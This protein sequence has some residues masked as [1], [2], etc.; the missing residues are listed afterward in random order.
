[1]CPVQ[2]NSTSLDMNVQGEGQVMNAIRD[3]SGDG[4]IETE[5]ADTGSRNGIVTIY[6]MNR[7][8]EARLR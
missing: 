7:V 4:D 5:K 2:H 6:T 3:G 1:M 8:R